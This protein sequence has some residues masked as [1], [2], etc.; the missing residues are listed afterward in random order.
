MSEII[1]KI[2]IILNISPSKF[3]LYFHYD[4]SISNEFQLI[5]LKYEIY[6]NYKIIHFNIE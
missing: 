3:Y 5:K 1:N 4:T 2:F 6:I